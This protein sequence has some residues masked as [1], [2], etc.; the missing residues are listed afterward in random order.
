[1]HYLTAEEVLAIHAE[2]I[3]RYGGRHGLRDLGLLES[4]VARP[5]AGFGA[6]EAYPMLWNK[7][8][9]LAHS[10]IHNHAFVDGNKRTGLVSA[11]IFLERNG[12]QLRCSQ[13]AF[14]RCALAIA[15]H[16]LDESGIAAWLRDHSVR[17]R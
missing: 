13:R 7:A 9:V 2:L 15:A 5:R 14:V 1:M 11:V 10:L 4:A 6:F 16:Q 3:D 12:Y 8:A 17:N